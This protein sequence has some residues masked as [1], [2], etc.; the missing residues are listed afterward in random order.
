MLTAPVRDELIK[1]EYARLL[2]HVGAHPAE[3]DPQKLSAADAMRADPRI[4]EHKKTAAT[5]FIER[6][7]AKGLTD[8]DV[9]ANRRAG[10]PLHWKEGETPKEFADRERAK[11]L[12]WAEAQPASEALFLFQLGVKDRD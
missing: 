1:E 6:A 2:S 11:N 8:A 12:A 3:R 7:E 5:Y 9:E 10:R 4:Q